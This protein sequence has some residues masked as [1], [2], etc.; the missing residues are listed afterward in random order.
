MPKVSQRRASVTISDVATAAGVSRSTVSRVM[1]G[2]A[3]VDAD[4][5]ERVRAAAARLNYR[6]SNIARS[7]SLG[8]TETVAFVVPE[9]ENPMFQHVLAGLTEAAAASGYRVLVADTG[10]NPDDEAAIALEARLRCD[11]LALVS[12]RMPEKQ[13][14]EL[15]TQ[16]SPTVLVNRDSPNPAAP[17]VTVNYRAGA[18]AVLEHLVGL[19]HRRIVYLSGP[20]PSTSDDRRRAGLEDVAA[21]TDGLELVVVPGGATVNAGYRA[22]EPVLAA[23]A[24]AVVA[25]NDLVAFGLLAALNQAGV[26]VP[27]DL[28]VTGFDD[29][30]LAQYSTPTLTTAAVPQHELGRHAWQELHAVIDQHEGHASSSTRFEPRL[31]VRAST[32]PVPRSVAEGGLAP[33]GTGSVSA[34]APESTATSPSALDSVHSADAPAPSAPQWRQDGEA[35]VLE[36][37]GERLARYES[38]ERL[39]VV[40]ARRPYLHP[41]HTLGG[42]VVTESGP[43]DHRHHYGASIAVPDVNGTSYWGG[44]TFVRDVGPTLL[45]NHGRQESAGARVDSTDHHVLYDAV[46]WYDE[47]DVPQVEESRTL[48]GHLLPSHEAWALSWRTILRADH[49]ALTIGS[50][51]T[52]GRPGAGYGGWFW[53]LPLE[54]RAHVLSAAGD[55]EQLAHG[56]RSPWLAFVQRRPSGTTTWLAVQHGKPQPWFVRADEYPGAGP[57]LAWDEPLSV[58][59]GGTVE[60]GLTTV[61]L[62]RALSHD[63]AAALAAEAASIR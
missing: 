52:N 29:I 20:T 51:A 30:E 60:I 37:A 16:A 40:H 8:R 25:F 11:A 3:T 35:L 12:P 5:S 48:S 36:W 34:A 47:E 23:R 21:V 10:Q 45:P 46:R 31:E 61:L 62:D 6:P 55:S 50:P 9:L 43:V 24:T 18:S 44:R 2:R 33:V 17:A 49:G 39:P 15:L 4:I 59:A 42:A 27:K 22:L 63:E 54:G 7:L 32:G 13:L 19:G 26:A 53:R 57:A 58:P 38:G 14:A 28:S 41:V 56:S 1:N